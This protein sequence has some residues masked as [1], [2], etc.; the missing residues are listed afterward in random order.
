MVPAADIQRY[1]AA[2]VELADEA[3]RIITPALERG[4]TVKTKADASLVTEVDQAIERRARELIDRWFPDHGV[5]GEEYPPT[6]PDSPFQWIIDP[7]DGTEEFV[8]GIPTFGTMLAL[9]HRGVP[10]VGVIDH[11]AL[12]LRVNAGFGLGAFRNGQRIR[13]A[14]A[15]VSQEP[16]HVRLALSARI[17]F[18]RHIDEGRLFETLTR[19]Y[20]NHRIYRAAYAHTATVT[21]AV[22]AMV[23]MHNHVWDLAPSKV[24]IEEAGGVY[25]V[26]RDFPAADGGRL[27]SAVFGKPAVVERLLAVFHSSPV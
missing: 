9:H 15:P 19:L 5:I 17:N 23:D 26:V 18:A 25:E 10:L 20:P 7:I 12:D 13:L 3:R 24:L 1:H 4:F 11:A 8:H 27:L 22:D 21:G 2:A 6:R 16:E 14:A